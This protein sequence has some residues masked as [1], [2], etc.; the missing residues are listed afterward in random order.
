[1]EYVSYCRGA[2]DPAPERRDLPKL[3]LIQSH[4]L[5]VTLGLASGIVAQWVAR[6]DP[7][8][9]SGRLDPS[10]QLCCGMSERLFYT[11]RLWRDRLVGVLSMAPG[12]RQ[13]GLSSDPVH[14]TA[15]QVRLR[16]CRKGGRQGRGRLQYKAFAFS[17]TSTALPPPFRTIR[18]GEIS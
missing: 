17:Y 7:P 1:M 13:H 18:P 15:T 16:A 6:R 10:S 8:L 4:L 3:T 14:R 11:P 5:G 12:R 9:L 2:E